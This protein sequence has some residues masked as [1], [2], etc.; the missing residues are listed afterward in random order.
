MPNVQHNVKQWEQVIHDGT[1]Q[2]IYIADVLHQLAEKHVC[3][4]L[5]DDCTMYLGGGEFPRGI[6]YKN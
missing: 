1:I 3:Q 2:V 4:S 6:Q 5:G